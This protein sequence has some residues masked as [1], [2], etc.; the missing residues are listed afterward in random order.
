MYP[1]DLEKCN[2]DMKVLW[3]IDMWLKMCLTGFI[4]STVTSGPHLKDKT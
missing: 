2:Q 1:W 3:M 4:L